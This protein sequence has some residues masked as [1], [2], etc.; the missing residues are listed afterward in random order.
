MNKLGKY[1]VTKRVIIYEI[2]AFVS[3]IVFIWLDEIIDLPHLLW[4][5]QPTPLNWQEAAF[6]TIFILVLSASIIA[7][8]NKILHRL[9]Y[10][11]GIISICASCKKIRDEEGYWNQV[12]TYIA[13]HSEAQFSHG[14]CEECADKL[15]GNESW[16]KKKNKSNDTSP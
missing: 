14:I 16:Y 2:V 5:A 15:Y 12:E 11:E 6:E 8:T 13:D 1:F 3:L 7:F 4:R 10:L 9:K